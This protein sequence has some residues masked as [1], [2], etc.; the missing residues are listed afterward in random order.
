MYPVDGQMHICALRPPSETAAAAL[1]RSPGAVYSSPS[2]HESAPALQHPT[3]V[4]SGSVLSAD[5]VTS[6][7]SSAGPLMTTAQELQQGTFLAVIT[8]INQC[9]FAII[10]FFTPGTLKFCSACVCV[11]YNCARHSMLFELG[12]IYSLEEVNYFIFISSV[13]HVYPIVCE[14]MLFYFA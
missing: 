9:F 4:S 12:F 5:Q 14:F 3:T 7:I 11:L 10:S 1:S 6:Q 13:I 2:T 8:A